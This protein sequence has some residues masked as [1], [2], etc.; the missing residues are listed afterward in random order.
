KALGAHF[1]GFASGIRPHAPKE[2][3]LRVAQT[4]RDARADLLIAVGGGSVCD[5]GKIVTLC[6][7]HDVRTEAELSRYKVQFGADGKIAPQSHA[8][9]DVRVVCVPT[10]LSGAEFNSLSGAYDAQLRQKQ[11]FDHRLMAPIA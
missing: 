4:A 8:G 1:A 2:D 7:K 3:I 9:P 10:T 6:L 11:G 5:A